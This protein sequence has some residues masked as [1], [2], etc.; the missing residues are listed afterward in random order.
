MSRVTVQTRGEE[1]SPSPASRI[2]G[3]ATA[4][5][6]RRTDLLS[7]PRSDDL[8]KA[9]GQ[10]SRNHIIL[11]L[12][13]LM[14][15]GVLHPSVDQVARTAHVSVRTVYNH[16]HDREHLVACAVDVGLVSAIEDVLPVPAGAPRT[17]RI[18]ATCRQRRDLFEQL[19]TFE[20]VVHAGALANEELRTLL[21]RH[22]AALRHQ[23]ALA[24]APELLAQGG[25]GPLLLDQL[26]TAA[27]WEH[28]RELREA[29]GCSAA[30]AETIMTT[31][32]ADI[33]R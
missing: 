31:F 25:R 24:F 5:Q 10:R 21:G 30:T 2:L 32:L 15:S 12:L 14:R 6:R 28:W 13:D 11:A 8:R 27:S 26:A 22:H 29:H 20:R 4:P 7:D 33:L 1:P 17:F 23:L 16:F 3:P 19:D 18:R 9:R